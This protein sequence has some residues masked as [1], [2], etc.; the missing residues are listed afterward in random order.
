MNPST[1]FLLGLINLPF[2]IPSEL[3]GL[4]IVIIHDSERLLVAGLVDVLAHVR[5]V[6]PKGLGV[7]VMA[8]QEFEGH[9]AQADLWLLKKT[10]TPWGEFV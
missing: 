1:A 3:F 10:L 4:T 2:K 6:Q 8:G 9:P 7:S 5:P